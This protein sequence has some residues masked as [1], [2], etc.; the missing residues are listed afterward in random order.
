MEIAIVI[1]AG[2]LCGFFT[3]LAG[4]GTAITLPLLIFLG[5]SPAVASGTNRLTVVVAT[6][7][8]SITFIRAGLI[9]WALAFKMITPTVLGC[10]LGTLFI[11]VIPPKVLEWIIVGSVVIALILILTSVKQMLESVHNDA[12][13]FRFQ[14]AFYLFL[15]G[16]WMGLVFLEGAT[17]LLIVLI[18]ALRLQLAIANAYKSIII[19]SAVTISFFILDYTGDINWRLSILLAIGGIVGGYIGAKFSMHESA[20][21]WTYRV[22]VVIILVELAHLVVFIYKGQAMSVNNMLM[23]MM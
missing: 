7:A 15:I 6:L 14:D 5:L 12:P 20:K 4:S 3:T 19:F 10:I 16:V 22:L 2:F 1:A 8:A 21:K 17:F 9:N 13:R 11:D 23:P 18:L